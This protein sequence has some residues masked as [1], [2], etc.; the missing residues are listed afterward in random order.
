[1]EFENKIVLITGASKGIGA[2][3]AKLFAKEGA[4][5]IINYYKSEELAKDILENVKKH[6]SGMIIKCDVTNEG[7]VKE[8]VDK[9]IQNYSKI[10]V[11]VNNVGGYLNGDEWNGDSNLWK[12]SLDLNITSTLNV[13]KYVAQEFLKSNSGIIVNV[14]S[15]FARMGNFEEITYGASKAAIL[16]ITQAY[17]KLLSSYGRVN[18]VSPGATDAGYW[19]RAPKDELE[20]VVSKSPHK[21][22][23]N[24]QDIA[25][26]ILFLSSKKSKMITGEDI[27]VDGGK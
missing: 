21:K 14:A 22:L 17:S 18:S 16:N 11:L 9:I 4:I 19:K 8:M 7:E 24:P 27:L 20:E 25:E 1:M 15:R 6:S 13:S 10:D 12:K 3:T 2:Q 23:V 26:T 5:V